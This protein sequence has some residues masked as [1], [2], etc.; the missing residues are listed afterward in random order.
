MNNTQFVLKRCSLILN[1]ILFCSLLILTGKGETQERPIK[2]GDSIE[3]V[4]YGHQEL[5]RVVFVSPQG[6]IDFP[7]LQSVPVDGLSLDKLRDLIVAQLSRFLDT[8]PIV[9][10]SFAKSQTITVSVM[11]HVK[12]PGV[13]GLPLQSRLQGA[14]GGAGGTLPGAKINEIT[15]LREKDG[16]IIN[17]TYNLELFILQGDMQQNP[18]LIDGDII[19]ITANLM[20]TEVK[21]FGSVNDP[22]N[23][24]SFYGA[25]VIDM[26]FQAGGLANDADQS[27]IRYISPSTEMEKSK[28]IRIDLNE[29][30]KA[31]D[32]YKLTLVKAGD[33]IIV[34]KK[35]KS[36]WGTTLSLARDFL[37]VGQFLYYYYLVKRLQ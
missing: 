4:V 8:R 31:P 27:K 33:I 22:G 35:K 19:L 30:L 18:T 15:L 17:S 29:Y 25:T 36:I 13:F 1:L 10:V 2:P 20:L 34:P 28:E 26:I 9:T 16:E 24:G 12:N 11:G 23:Y 21:V 32:D 5:S 14:I 3:I 6:T 7:F 37:V